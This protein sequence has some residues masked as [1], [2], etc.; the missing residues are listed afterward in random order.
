[1]KI[2]KII[3]F[4]TLGS[5]LFSSCG[6]DDASPSTSTLNASFDKLENLGDDAT[7]EG[8]IIVDGNPISTGVFTVNDEGTPSKT[9]FDIDTEDLRNATAFVLTIEPS[10]DN[11]PAPSDVHILA[12]DISGTSASLSISHPAALGTSFTGATGKYILAT[13]TN[14]EENDENSGVWFIDLTSGMP[15]AGLDLPALP[16]AGWAYEGWAVIDGQPVSTGTFTTASGADDFDGFS[17]G[18]AGPP[19]PGEDFLVNAPSGLTF[20]LDL[21]GATIVVSI[22]PVPDNS[23]APFV[24]KPLAGDVEANAIDHSTFELN[25]IAASTYPSGSV[26]FEL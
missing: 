18:D 7:Y 20:P 10:P 6:D 22:E 25:N 19:F 4:L 11:D 24:L 26:N 17:G 3:F 8:W 12:G 2:I 16:D 13:P 15:A 14:G 23:P 9:G 5:F 1:M 21:S